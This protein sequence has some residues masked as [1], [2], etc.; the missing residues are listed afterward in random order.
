MSASYDIET[1]LLD[2]ANIQDTMV[3]MVSFH[4]PALRAKHADP[5][6]MHSFDTRATSTL[7]NL[8]YAP[9]V[10]LDYDPLLGGSPEV[11][12]SEVWAKK[13][14]HIHDPYDSTQHVVQ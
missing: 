8:V 13:L 14:E 1:Y 5:L 4:L 7:I 10:H 3:R 6:Q 2:K 12:S 9:E 11:V